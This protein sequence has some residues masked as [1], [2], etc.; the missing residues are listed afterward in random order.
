LE[1]H[2]KW[3][4]WDLSK[5]YKAAASPPLRTEF[6]QAG[7]ANVMFWLGWL[8][9]SELFERH[10]DELHVIHP[11]DAAVYD[12]PTACGAVLL[13][14]GLETKH[15]RDL[16]VDVVL[17]YATRSGFRVGRWIKRLLTARG[18]RKDWRLSRNSLFCHPD[19]S[20]WTSAY[21]RET[22]LYPALNEQ[23][24]LGDP[25]LQ[26]FTTTPGDRI[27]DRFWSLHCYRRGV[28]PMFQN[29][30][31]QRHPFTEPPRIKS[32]NMPVGDGLD[33]VKP[34]MFYIGNG[35]YGTAYG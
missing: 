24:R 16:T 23:Q 5:R 31:N 20:Q 2:V 30:P 4:D 19:G 3:I 15:R 11:A 18:L 33:L 14:L 17:A 1:R 22:Y 6:A 28:D 25:F 21:N 7:L 32:T 8:R 35:P 29:P 13:D 26:Q 12:L 34:L 9:S 10:F 27:R